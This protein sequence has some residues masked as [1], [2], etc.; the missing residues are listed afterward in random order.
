MPFIR[1]SCFEMPLANVCFGYWWKQL[2]SLQQ[3]AELL[4]KEVFE[5]RLFN[6]EGRLHK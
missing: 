2:Q 3:W 5:V 1:H 4:Q 6:Q